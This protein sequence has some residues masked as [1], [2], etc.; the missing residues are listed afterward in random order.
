MK[1]VIYKKNP[2]IEVILQVR[3]PTILTINSNDPVEFQEKIRKDYPVYQLGIEREQE[4]AIIAKED[5]FFP[6]LQEKKQHKNHAFV[7]A[8]GKYKVNLTSSFI[9]ISTVNYTRWEDFFE[10]FKFVL[11]SFV[12]V[13]N[14]SFYE[15]IGLRYIDAFSR[16]KLNITDKSWK[17]LIQS[18]WIGPLSNVNEGD[19]INLGI[20][21]EYILDNNK[22]RIKVHTGL[23]VLNNA[24][25][26]FI[27]DSDFI[28]PLTVALEEYEAIAE[29]LHENSG[30]FIR[31]VITSTLHEAMEPGELK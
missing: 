3:F 18:P 16:E 30:K 24:E 28:H 31:S 13:Y 6:S 2:L 27:V 20:D 8:D 10:K 9:S 12:E 26:V 22:S 11:S 23:G 5:S 4:L 29:Y 19:I 21:T 17:E 14:P 15:R 1:R 25:K 7:S